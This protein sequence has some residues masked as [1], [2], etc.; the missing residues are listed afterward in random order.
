MVEDGLSLGMAPAL[1]MRGAGVG[2][3]WA[4]RWDRTGVG[5]MESERLEQG[6]GRLGFEAVDTFDLYHG[7]MDYGWD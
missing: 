4:W 2:R 6:A 5:P 3:S 1:G 7:G